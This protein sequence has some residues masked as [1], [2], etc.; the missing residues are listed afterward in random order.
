MRNNTEI[1]NY[2]SSFAISIRAENRSTQRGTYPY[3]V[4]LKRLDVGRQ[5]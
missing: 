4:H 1:N 2:F 3:Y 5:I